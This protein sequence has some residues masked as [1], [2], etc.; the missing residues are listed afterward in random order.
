[1]SM[2]S[3]E[4]RNPW[5]RNWIPSRPFEIPIHVVYMN[6]KEGYVERKGTAVTFPRRRVRNADATYD[7]IKLDC[8]LYYVAALIKLYLAP[9]AAPYGCLCQFDSIHLS[10]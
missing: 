8:R 5:K 9:S 1:M 3:S 7:T 2:T 6:S 10:A 4:A